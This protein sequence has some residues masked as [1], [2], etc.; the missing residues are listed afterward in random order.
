MCNRASSQL[1]AEGNAAEDGAQVRR[2]RAGVRQLPHAV[3]GTLLTGVSGNT[4]PFTCFFNA[5]AMLSHLSGAITVIFMSQSDRDALRSCPVPDDP[6]MRDCRFLV[7]KSVVY[8]R[9]PGS[10]DHPCNVVTRHGGRSTVCYTHPRAVAGQRPN[11]FKE[12]GKPGHFGSLSNIL[13]SLDE[14]NDFCGSGRGAVVLL[15]STEGELVP[16]SR[17]G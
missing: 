12:Q 10:T 7:S 16:G 17:T 8:T 6:R 3:Q 4:L 11:T 9:I 1:V 14:D 13:R 5:H 15:R 2:K